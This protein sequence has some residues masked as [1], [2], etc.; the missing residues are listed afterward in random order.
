MLQSTQVGCSRANSRC[1]FPSALVSPPNDDYPA[2][3]DLP[4]FTVEE[5]PER[6]RPEARPARMHRDG[7]ERHAGTGLMR[8]DVVL[9][10][11]RIDPDAAKVV[12]RLE[13]AGHQ[14][15]LVGGCVG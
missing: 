4:S 6:S 7:A 14:A 15:Y 3:P 9:D 1:L 8:H 12:R 2:P 13:R 11:E 10:D 5:A